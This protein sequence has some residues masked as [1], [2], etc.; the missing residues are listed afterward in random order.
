MSNHLLGFGV[1]S[2]VDVDVDSYEKCLWGFWHFKMC[3][4]MIY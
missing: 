1:S 4:V 2:D 3:F